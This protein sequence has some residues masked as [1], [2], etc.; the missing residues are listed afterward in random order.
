MW[1]S[2]ATALLRL[3]RGDA[4][5][6]LAFSRQSV[7]AAQGNAFLH[8]AAHAGKVSLRAHSMQANLLLARQ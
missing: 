3:G 7:W 6:S 8:S 5:Q 2:H 1:G 4:M